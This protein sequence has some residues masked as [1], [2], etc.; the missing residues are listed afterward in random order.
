MSILE[1]IPDR[2]WSGIFTLA[3]TLTGA[4]M[5]F[6]LSFWQHRAQS[7]KERKNE[8]IGVYKMAIDAV[9]HYIDVHQEKLTPETP[10]NERLEWKGREREARVRHYKSIAYLRMLGED[11]IADD[12]KKLLEF[13][14]SHD[15]E[16]LNSNWDAITRERVYP[17]IDKLER[18]VRGL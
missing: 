6:S 4:L 2:L 9:C 8:L 1:S 18:K 15:H 7:K 12:S 13:I 5:G 3:G 11:D 10:Y 16:N 17:I 14:R